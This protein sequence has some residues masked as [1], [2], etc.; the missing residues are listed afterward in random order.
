MSRQRIIEGQ[1]L[2]GEKVTIVKIKVKI[3]HGQYVTQGK[4]CDEK[5]Q[6]FSL[7][8]MRKINIKDA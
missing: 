7:R 6:V 5:I 1:E 3:C 4:K 8:R 2:K